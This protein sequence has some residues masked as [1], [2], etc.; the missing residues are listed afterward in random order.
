MDAGKAPLSQVQTVSDSLTCSTRGSSF[1]TL[2]L[3]VSGPVGPSTDW[4]AKPSLGAFMF[5]DC[6]SYRRFQGQNQADMDPG[7]VK[8]AKAVAPVGR[9]CFCCRFRC[10]L[11]VATVST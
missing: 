5:G 10:C 6:G 4:T 1:S 9:M 8:A 2:T 3:R 11:S 7:R